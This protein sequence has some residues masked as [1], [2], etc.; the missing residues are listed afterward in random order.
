MRKPRDSLSPLRGGNCTERFALMF[1]TISSRST[2]D[3]VDILKFSAGD[4][5]GSDNDDNNTFLDNIVVINVTF[6]LANLLFYL[7]IVVT[8]TTFTNHFRDNFSLS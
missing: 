3:A 8:T 5:D 1:Q 6:S 4:N 7:N 2:P